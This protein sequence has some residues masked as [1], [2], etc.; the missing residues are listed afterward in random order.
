MTR[1]TQMP[2]QDTVDQPDELSVRWPSDERLRTDCEDAM[3]HGLSNGE[4]RLLAALIYF[5]DVGRIVS[6]VGFSTLAPQVGGIDKVKY[7]RRRLIERGLIEIVEYGFGG[8]ASTYRLI[9]RRRDDERSLEQAAAELAFA[10][11]ATALPLP[12]YEAFAMAC[13]RAGAVVVLNRDEQVAFIRPAGL[14]NAKERS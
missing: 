1:V 14:L 11:S 5:Q 13:A 3:R 8:V 10:P 2:G 9:F 12:M 4:Y 6:G 7:Y